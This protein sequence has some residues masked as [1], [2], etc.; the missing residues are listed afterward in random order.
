MNF[1]YQKARNLMVENQ[2]RPN[3]IKDIDILNLFNEMP[4]EEFLSKDLRKLSYSD[5]DITMS[6]NRGYLKNLHIAQLIKH[7]EIN[8]N[9]KVLHI[10]ALSGYVSFLLANLSEEVSV[11]EVE[12]TYQEI[13]KKNIKD[14]EINNIELVDGSFIEGFVLNAPYDLI[15]IDTPIEL[16]D[17]KILN[18]LSKNLGKLIMIKRES[19]ILSRAVKITRNKDKFSE[20]YLFDVFSKYELYE[21]EKG[22]V[23]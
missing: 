22:F 8:K 1:N 5:M 20:E 15:F 9:C 19:Q 11:I 21:K 23:F 18:Q 14:F 3:K 10:G 12:K 7:S 13:L 17:P 6:K 2:L 16:I 4:K